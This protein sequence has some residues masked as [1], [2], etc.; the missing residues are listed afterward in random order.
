MN[1]SLSGLYPLFDQPLVDQ[2]AKAAQVRAVGAGI[3]FGRPGVQHHDV[4]QVFPGL[5]EPGVDVR[6]DDFQRPLGRRR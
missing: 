6:A 5:V 2:P 3:A 4:D 1:V